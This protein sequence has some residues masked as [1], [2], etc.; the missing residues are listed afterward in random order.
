MLTQ[1]LSH[2]NIPYLTI[3]I[4]KV[5]LLQYMILPVT[6]SCT[7]KVNNA[8]LRH[9]QSESN[10]KQH[11]CSNRYNHGCITVELQQK[12]IRVQPWSLPRSN[13]KRDLPCGVS[14]CT[15]RFFSS[16][17]WMAK[18]LY[19]LWFSYPNINKEIVNSERKIYDV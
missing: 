17:V 18:V 14:S 7:S 3:L 12:S 4:L 9:P 8:Y 19:L 1:N 15:A 10:M 13:R 11:Y 16:F 5:S 2:A 6:Q